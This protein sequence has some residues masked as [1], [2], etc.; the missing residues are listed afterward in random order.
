MK[1]KLLL[2]ANSFPY[3]TGEKAF[4]I[5]E[6]IRLKEY[7]DITV[8][9]HADSQQIECGYVEAEIMDGIKSFCF[10]RPVIHFTDKAK[11]LFSYLC[12]RDGRQ[13]IREI[14]KQRKHLTERLY[15]SL[16][17]YAQALADQK[18]IVKSGII[19]TDEPVIYYSFWNT[20]YCYSMVREQR[21]LKNVKIVSRLH[22]F[23]LYQER[24]PGERQPFKHQMEE[25]VCNLIFLGDYAKQY[26]IERIKD[27]KTAVNKMIVCPLGTEAS[28]RKMP[29]TTEK[30]WRLLSCSDVIPLKRVERIIDG[31]S[32][33]NAEQIHW[34]HIGAGSELESIQKYAHEKLAQKGNIQYTFMGH[35]EHSAVLQY[36][37]REQVDCFITTSATEGMPVSVM[38][39]MSYGIPIIATAVGGIPEMIRESGVLLSEDPTVSEIAWAIT[40]L[41]KQP[42]DQIMELKANTYQKWQ[43]KYAIDVTISGLL[44]ILERV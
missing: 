18:E 21:T 1:K 14:M 35:M 10:Q 17:F 15:Q 31:L 41:M 26:Y 33:I 36:Y 9:S 34:T 5:P 42:M 4:I 43:Q 2:A 24:I 7:F 13:E 40:M 6:L 20:Y 32:E 29:L 28:G 16:S 25:S 23:D 38:E 30:E 44:K 12:D 19:E 37:E 27:K 11:A 39:A 22:G 3:N 8:I